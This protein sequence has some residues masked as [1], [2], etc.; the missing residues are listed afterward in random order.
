MQLE[1]TP[2]TLS[3]TVDT[4]PIRVLL[5][6]DNAIEAK[7][8]SA[9]FAKRGGSEFSLE[10]ARTL[11]EAFA[12][13]ENTSI[14]V[15]L[16]DLFLTETYGLQTLSI[17]R[18][19]TPDVPVVVLTGLNDEAIAL[20]ALKHGAQDYLIKGSVDSC[21]LFRVIRYARERRLV[22]AERRSLEQRSLQV[23]KLEALGTLAGGVA[24]NF[25]N[26][27]MAITGHAHLLLERSPDGDSKRHLD[28]IKRAATRASALTHQLLMFGHKETGQ[29]IPLDLNRIVSNTEE[30]IRSVLGHEIAVA[31]ELAQKP[32]QISAD[33][34]QMQHMI[35][36]LVLNAR[37]AIAPGGRVDIRTEG[38]HADAGWQ[39]RLT[40]ADDGCGMSEE[41]LAHIFEPFYTTRGLAVAA[42]LGLSTI[43]G[44]V[45][46][47]SGKIR[48]SSVK[49]RGSA[50]EITL[51]GLG[52]PPAV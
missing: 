27:L 31:F 19:R 36:S 13:L 7:F 18:E 16:L 50:F 23:R 33:P 30:L 1:T 14:D 25:N 40:I 8:L 6:E 52:E 35:M 11:S 41:T 2:S 44:I 34:I 22:E 5:V 24:H 45:E 4:A 32:V 10:T 49:G 12:I 38:I 3:A 51:P 39:A 17:V 9:D 29:R 47:H 43:Y 46:Y 20:Q 42:G 28:A 26:I 15:I 48:V 21:A 37:D